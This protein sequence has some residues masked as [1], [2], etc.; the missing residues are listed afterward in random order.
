MGRKFIPAV[1][2][3]PDPE[4]AIVEINPRRRLLIRTSTGNGH[5]GSLEEQR[6]AEN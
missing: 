6:L 2:R 3:V 4:I 1:N 5:R